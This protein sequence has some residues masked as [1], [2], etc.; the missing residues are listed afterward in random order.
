M[1]YAELRRQLSAEPRRW[2]VTGA[3][4]FIGSALVQTLLELGQ[5]VTGL[6]NFLTGHQH[7]L[8]A[9]LA[10]L[11]PA[12][13]GK[14]CFVE[15]DIRDRDCCRQ[16]CEGA[17][18][19]LHQAALGSVPWSIRDP[20]AAHQCN[21]DGSLNM[22]LAARDAGVA[23]FV[24]ASS[25]AV[26]GDE[27][28]VPAVEERIGRPLSPYAAT[29]RM[30]E[31]YASTV[32]RTYGLETIGLRYFNVFGPR[33]DPRGPYA[34]VIPR[35]IGQLC[36]GERCV[37][38]GDGTQSRD[39]CHV[40]EVVQANLLSAAAPSSATDRIYNVGLG[41]A[42]TIAELYHTIRDGVSRHRPEVSEA[43]VEYAAPR[44]GDV[45]HS[46][47]E[48]TAIQRQLGFRPSR[49]VSEGL[50]D[51]IAWFVDRC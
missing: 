25:S 51:T 22:L 23:R 19:V 31:L 47:A 32:Q 30:G 7:N 33:Q 42:T 46:R 29:K 11:T 2:L 9:V 34:A 37:I 49:A 40:D 5:E 50:I 1:H 6:D 27:S 28:A 16:I 20:H 35:W 38:Y 48:L 15:G 45:Q 36:A 43:E 10:P 44:P 41:T 17:D 13:R 12:A 24:Y 18:Y 39:F 26:Y 4:G 21:V 14:L 3:A 8:D